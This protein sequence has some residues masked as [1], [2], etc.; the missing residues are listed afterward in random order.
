MK[1]M[2]VSELE[3]T[4]RSLENAIHELD[5][6]GDHMTPEDRERAAELKRLRLVAKDRLDALR[7]TRD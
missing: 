2:D 4:A 5:R 3:Q 1:H 6:R 7:T